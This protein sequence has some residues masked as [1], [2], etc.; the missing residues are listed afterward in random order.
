MF[1]NSILAHY[2]LLPMKKN[3]LSYSDHKDNW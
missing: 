1:Q 2:D 3:Q